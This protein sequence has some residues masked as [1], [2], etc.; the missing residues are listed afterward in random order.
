MKKYK[1]LGLII[2]G[3][4]YFL[5]LMAQ[6]KAD[7]LNYVPLTF[8]MYLQEVAQSNL[9]L[10]AEK[11]QINLAEAEVIAAKILPDPELSFEGTDE[12]YS[13]ELSYPLDIGNK[14]RAR[15]R[16]AQGEVDKTQLEWDYFFQQLRA[17][18]AYAFVDALIE[19]KLLAVKESSFQNMNQLSLSDSIRF[20][21]G[22]ITQNDVRQ[23]KLEA[24]LL[25]NELYQQEAELKTSLIVLNQYMGK[26]SGDLYYPLGSWDSVNIDY[27]LSELLSIALEQ[28]KD[29]KSIEKSMELAQQMLK[30]I[31]AERRL[32]V[33]LMI[34]YERDWK[35][36]FPT[37]NS[38]KAGVSI[39]LKFSNLN[40]GSVHAK[41]IAVEKSRYDIQQ[42]QLQVEVEVAQGYYQYEAAQKRLKQYQSG[43]LDE[44]Q[45][46][47][48]GIFYKYHRGDTSILEVLMAQRTYNE[49]QEHYIEVMKEYG[50]A[51]I[52]LQLICGFWTLNF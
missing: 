38:M 2:S 15:V 51:L 41:R 30:L 26:T 31:R 7:T 17:E 40:K 42:A 23:S 28:R 39:P 19:Q 14:R 37:G 6:N 12:T 49:V 29:L 8:E 13:L 4:F 18:A 25:K 33:G 5:G 1:Y 52:Q 10:L 47:L 32:D 27:E 35:G 45:K 43:M 3:L 22:E 36:P 48:D 20:T 34:G 50:Y 16:M 11:K 21:L 46:V 24:T 9:Q 44:S